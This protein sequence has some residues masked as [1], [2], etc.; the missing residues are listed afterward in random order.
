M[1]QEAVLAEELRAWPNVTINVGM[2]DLHRDLLDAFGIQK[3]AN[4]SV[5]QPQNCNEPFE[6]WP[7]IESRTIEPSSGA[8]RDAS[9]AALARWLR[10]FR[11][12]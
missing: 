9:P 1:K 6:D 7:R 11:S 8:E 5:F 2:F 12:A 3:I 4:W 10:G